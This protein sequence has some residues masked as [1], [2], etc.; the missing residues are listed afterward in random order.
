MLSFLKREVE[1]TQK[2]HT[3]ESKKRSEQSGGYLDFNSAGF[4]KK[5]IIPADAMM[6]R[7]MMMRRSTVPASA[8]LQQ[9]MMLKR[10][11]GTLD[12]GSQNSMLLPDASLP[13]LKKAAQ[14]QLFKDKKAFQISR[15]NHRVEVLEK[16][17][18]KMANYIKSQAD[19][20]EKR[21]IQGSGLGLQ[22]N[23]HK[24]SFFEKQNGPKN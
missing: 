5:S 7:L 14:K 10:N 19:S 3:D 4:A 8:I 12:S 20:A 11:S 1:N 21:S 9:M 6:E 16:F 13:L 24:R 18:Q 23:A 15:L 17:V 22:T 2:L